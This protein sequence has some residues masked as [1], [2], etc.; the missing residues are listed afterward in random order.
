M[1]TAS[2]LMLAAIL[3]LLAGVAPARATTLDQVRSSGVLRLGY[4][5]EA[6]PFSYRDAS[7]RPSG[8]VLALCEKVAEAVAAELRLPQ[9]KTEYV[10]VS[11]GE[12]RFDAV[13]QGKVDL[14]CAGG[15]PTAARRKVVSFSIPVFLGGVAALMRADAP[16]ELQ[17]ALEGRPEPYKPRWRAS[18][19]QVL[20]DRSFAVVRGT[21]TSGWLESRIEQLGVPAKIDPVDDFATAVDRVVA[22]RDD[23]LFADRALVLTAAAS[24]PSAGDLIVLDRYF[25]HEAPALALARGDEE[26]R[27]LVDRAL[28][29][30]L[31]SGDISAVYTPYFG[32]PS[33]QTLRFFQATSL[34][35]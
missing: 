17:A 9:L 3:L 35:E 8:Y 6:R 2:S 12:E 10:E 29:Q 30:L 21:T 16:E 24:S 20:R 11:S 18:L 15:A 25:T 4:L 5:A 1:Q 14:L 22:R 7:G 34:P 27:L 31:R 28:S 19:G 26:F 33:Q 13:A 32:K 23:V